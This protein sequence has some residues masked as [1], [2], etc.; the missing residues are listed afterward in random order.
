VSGIFQVIKIQHCDD[1]Y[2]HFVFP[3]AEIHSRK[4]GINQALTARKWAGR[5]VKY[6]YRWTESAT[7][8]V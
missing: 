4:T 2:K 1:A 6:E 5:W 7:D 3:A 8:F